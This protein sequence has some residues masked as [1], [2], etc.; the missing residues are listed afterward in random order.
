MVL[1]FKDVFVGLQV[2]E[3]LG[4]QHFDHTGAGHPGADVAQPVVGAFY[5][6]TLCQPARV[7]DF[8]APFVRLSRAPV[9]L[10]L[11]EWACFTLLYYG[12]P[13]PD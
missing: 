5:P 12:M 13:R 7:V 1:E 10:S 3:V 6:G 11:C 4:M 2:D 8:T 9:G